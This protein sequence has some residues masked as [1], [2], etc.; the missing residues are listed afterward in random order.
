MTIP[1]DSYQRQEAVFAEYRR[2]G[3]SHITFNGDLFNKVV[4]AEKASSWQ[5]FLGWVV[6]LSGEW[7]FRGQ[8]DSSWPLRTSLDRAVKVNTSDGLGPYTHRFIGEFAPLYPHP[9]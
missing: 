8:R 1:E 5:D 4:W 7:C 2:G 6:E 3:G 9:Q